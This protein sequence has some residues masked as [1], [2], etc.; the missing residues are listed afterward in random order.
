VLPVTLARRHLSRRRA[1]L[2]SEPRPFLCCH[3]PVAFLAILPERII[4]RVGLIA[5]VANVLLLVSVAGRR[6]IGSGFLWICY[7]WG[8]VGSSW[9]WLEGNEFVKESVSDK[10]LHGAP[11]KK[12]RK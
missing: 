8:G 12:W 11:S 1:F 9:S 3:N 7:A 4:C 5:I 2:A 10:R 6:F